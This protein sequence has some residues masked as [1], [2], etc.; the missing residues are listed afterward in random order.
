MDY[1][2]QLRENVRISLRGIWIVADGDFNHCQ[3]NRPHVG[4]DGVRS[5]VVL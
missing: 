4:G 2:R 1:R 5:D 3:P